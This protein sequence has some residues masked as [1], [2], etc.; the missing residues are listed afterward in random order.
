MRKKH[1]TREATKKE[2][3]FVAEDLE[4]PPLKLHQIAKNPLLDDCESERNQPKKQRNK[5]DIERDYARLGKPFRKRL[6]H[7]LNKMKRLKISPKDVLIIP[8]CSFLSKS[9]LVND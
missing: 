2:K 7:L 5:E 4:S 8:N 1:K 6:V 3:I 9:C